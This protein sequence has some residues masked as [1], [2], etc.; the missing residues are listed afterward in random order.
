MR[1]TCYSDVDLAVVSPAL[2]SDIIGE[3]V[4]LMNAFEDGEA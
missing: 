4:M 3:S 2:G 1:A